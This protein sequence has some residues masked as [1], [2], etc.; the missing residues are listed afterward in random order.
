M[1]QKIDDGND[2]WW[3]SI[4]QIIFDP[5]C[6]KWGKKKKKTKTKQYPYFLDTIKLGTR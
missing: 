3:I 1:Q 4:G 5:V 6:Q 2:K